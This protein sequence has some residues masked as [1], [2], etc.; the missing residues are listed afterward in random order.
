MKRRTFT[1]TASALLA[2]NL[3]PA[4][5]QTS[6]PDQIAMLL[7]PGMT[8]LDLIGPQQIFGYMTGVEIHLVGKSKEAVVS[9]TGVAIAPTKTF[10][11]CPEVLD[12]LFV[13][14]GGRGT[15]QAMRDRETVAFVRD[16]ASRAK[17]V[18]SVCTGSLILGAA[19][20]LRGYKATSHW[21]VRG[22]LPILGAESVDSRVVENRNRI[23]GAGI[24]SGL[25][26][27]FRL[28]GRL[29]GENFGRALELML[30]Y[31]PQPPFGTGSPAKAPAPVT[32]SVRK[33]YAPLVEACK[34]AAT[35]AA[36]RG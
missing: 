23:T 27:G 17:Y 4:A 33:L 13:P 24:T 32:E 18:T 9:D 5:E 35:E 12:I 3:L 14:G 28:A 36:A 15:V 19:G 21:A 2:A 25:D 10:A 31:D 7:Y 26:F 6:G 29:R 8:A 20:L 11:D 22:L 16:R 34:L 30:E 1:S